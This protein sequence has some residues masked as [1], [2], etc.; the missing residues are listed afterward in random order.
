MLH[1]PRLSNT[2]PLPIDCRQDEEPFMLVR[3]AITF[4]SG[5]GSEF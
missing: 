4:L 1:L 3:L 2:Y 5:G